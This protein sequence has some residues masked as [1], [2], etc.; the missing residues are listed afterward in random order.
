MQM[1]NDHVVVIQ[2]MQPNVPAQNL[3]GAENKNDCYPSVHNEEVM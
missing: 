2:I 3:L 1:L